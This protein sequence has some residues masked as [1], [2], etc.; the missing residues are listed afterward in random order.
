MATMRQVIIG[1]LR[2]ALG[3]LE[4]PSDEEVCIY[5]KN[6]DIVFCPE[7]LNKEVDPEDYDA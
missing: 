5:I 7:D 3:R 1:Q 6:M 4:K 2:T